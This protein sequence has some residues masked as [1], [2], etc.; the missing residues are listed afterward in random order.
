MALNIPVTL[1]VMSLSGDGNVGFIYVILVDPETGQ[2][3][4]QTNVPFD[5]RTGNY[6]YA[7]R[8]V[9]S[10]V[11]LVVAGTNP[12]YNSFIGELGEALGAYR[13]LD[14]PTIVESPGFNQKLDFSVAF[15]VALPSEVTSRTFGVTP[16]ITYFIP[17][18]V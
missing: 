16:Q 17:K 3:V 1:Q 12:D 14:L 7:F 4:G 10:G 15:R 2:T 8:N 9:P 6:R 13:T 5:P 18:R 11:Y